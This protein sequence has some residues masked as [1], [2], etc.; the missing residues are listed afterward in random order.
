MLVSGRVNVCFQQIRNHQ[1]GDS[2]FPGNCG[3]Q[4]WSLWKKFEWFVHWKMA[5]KIGFIMASSRCFRLETLERWRGHPLHPTVGNNP[6]FP[7]R[8]WRRASVMLRICDF[9]ALM[10]CPRGEA[11]DFF[12]YRTCFFFGR[13]IQ[14]IHP[15]ARNPRSLKF[16]GSLFW[17]VQIFE[18]KVEWSIWIKWVAIGLSSS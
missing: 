11:N 14:K 2:I 4:T 7:W 1:M 10:R 3:D 18:E 12:M 16:F 9:K 15:S 17:W 6:P 13:N 5:M 8:P